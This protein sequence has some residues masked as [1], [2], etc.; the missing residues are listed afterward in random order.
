ME[1]LTKLFSSDFPD[2]SA[3]YHDGYIYLFGSRAWDGEGKNIQVR[4]AVSWTGTW[5]NVGCAIKE[6]ASWGKHSTEFW[7]PDVPR[8]VGATFRLYYATN[9]DSVQGMAIAMAESSLP[10]KFV[11]A[12]QFLMSGD[13]YSV[14]DPFTLHYKGEEWLFWGSHHEPIRCRKLDPCGYKFA[15]HSKERIVLHPS[16]RKYERLLEGFF[17]FYHQSNKTWYAFVSGSDTW[18]KNSYA[19]TTFKSSSPFGPFTRV[20]LLI[21]PSESWYAPGQNSV[22]TVDGTHYFVCH[23]AHADDPYLKGTKRLKRVP[24]VAKLRIEH[25][26]PVLLPL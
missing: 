22:V 20:G 10:Y 25:D 23:A 14:V 13:G 19:V 15:K 18:D 5:E 3:L 24:C 7:C 21:Q 2:P 26:V 16:R 12:P 8:K 4:R 1:Q 17:L 9:P 11:P 6:R